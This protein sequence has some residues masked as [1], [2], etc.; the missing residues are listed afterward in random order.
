LGTGCV[1]TPAGF[2]VVAVDGLEQRR[3]CEEPRSV[4][5]RRHIFRKAAA[6]V[7]A[8][9]GHDGVRPANPFIR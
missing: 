3:A 9:F 4:D 5:D 1:G 8:L 7:A 6:S 2:V